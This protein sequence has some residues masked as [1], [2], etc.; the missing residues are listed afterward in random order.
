MERAQD[1]STGMRV[2]VLLRQLAGFSRGPGW[3]AGRPPGG[4]L[5]AK[6]FS[7]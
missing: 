6:F 7:R 5:D 2:L 1:G 4:R 3:S